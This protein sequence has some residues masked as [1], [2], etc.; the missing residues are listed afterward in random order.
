MSMI[1]VALLAWTCAEKMEQD[2]DADVSGLLGALQV[3]L[4]GTIPSDI[5]T[6]GLIAAS[7]AERCAPAA[8][9]IHGHIAFL[10]RQLL[11][12]DDKPPVEANPG[13]PPPRRPKHTK[14]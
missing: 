10:Q 11:G 4:G 7:L 9:L 14:G 13:T 1:R 8:V 3:A 5:A 2:P 12:R 6:L